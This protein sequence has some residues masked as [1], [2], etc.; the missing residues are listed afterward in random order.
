MRPNTST[1]SLA[2]R[3]GLCA[4]AAGLAFAAAPAFAQ[5]AGV[6][7][8]SYAPTVDELTIEGRLGP[9]G[10]NSL[11]RAVDI[12]DLDLRYDR[13]VR[14]MQRRVRTTARQICNELGE[15]GGPGVTPSCEDAAVRS[16][17]R[18]S[19][20]A[21]AQARSTTYYAYNAPAYVT[22][23]AG[24]YAPPASAVVPYDQEPPL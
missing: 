3:L 10:P 16:A 20:F 24:Q 15:H 5:P 18:Q 23:Y 22:P 8:Y 12:S 2:R 13:D 9:N 14:M 7:D 17:Q 1:T 11:S 19:R 4:A 6:P 21:I